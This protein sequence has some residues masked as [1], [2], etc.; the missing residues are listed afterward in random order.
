MKKYL[1][2]IVALFVTFTSANALEIKSL[3]FKSSNIEN[4]EL[5]T[6]EDEDKLYYM[7]SHDIY[8]YGENDT[9]K[10]YIRAI[11]NPGDLSFETNKDITNTVFSLLANKDTNE[12]SYISGKEYKWVKVKYNQENFN[13]LEYYIAWKDIFITVTVQLKEGDFNS[14]QQ[15]YFDNFVH[16]IKLDGKGKAEV[17]HVLLSGIDK[18]QEQKKKNYIRMIVLC[19]M[20]IGVTYWYTRFYNRKK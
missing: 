2:L 18:F 10:F 1:L 20:L 13:V 16:G 4:M 8:A 3:G 11:A 17:S 6:R 9:Y 12:Y 5:I 7:Y 15:Y 14:D 19:L